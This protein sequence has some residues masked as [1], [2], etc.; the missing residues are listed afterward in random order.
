VAST[1]TIPALDGVLRYA[2]NWAAAHSDA[3]VSVVLLT[4]VSP[5]ACDGFFGDHEAEAQRIARAGYEGVPSIKTYVVG[6]SVL[7]AAGPLAQAGGTQATSIS[8]TP[9]DG[10]VR[11][12]LENVRQDAQT[13]QFRLGNDFRLAADSAIVVTASNGAERRYP[14]LS[15]GAACAQQDGF[16]VEDPTAPYPLVACARTCSSLAATDRTA[17]S[18]ACASP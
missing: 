6:F 8:V 7:Q 16:Y 11:A 12:A 5:G 9:P 10:E 1:S 15:G 13:C 14:I 18:S 3:R 2:R 4:D 17:S